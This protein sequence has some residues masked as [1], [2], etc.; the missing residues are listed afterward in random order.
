MINLDE[1]RVR[2]LSYGPKTD[3]RL[4]EKLLQVDPDILIALEGIGTVKGVTL[5]DRF[6]ELLLSGK[7]PR[8]F[9]LKLHEESTRRGHASLTTSLSIQLEINKCSRAASML[10]VAPPFGSYIQESQRRRIISRDDFV[11]PRRIASDQ[12]AKRI[13]EKAVKE[14]YEVYRFLTDSGVEIEDARYV[15]PLAS[16]TSLFASGSLD[17]FLGFII[18][19]KKLGRSS[20]IYPEELSLIGEGI[21]NAALQ[22]APILTKAKLLFKTNLP[23]YPYANPYKNEDPLVDKIIEEAGKP[24]EPKLLSFTCLINDK[25][26]IL[27]ALSDPAKASSLLPLLNAIFLEPLSLAAYHQSIR[28]RT[29]PTA[30][31]SIY[32]A[33]DRLA[34]Q[35][36]KSAIIPPRIGSS[37][38]LLRRFEDAIGLL[39]ESYELLRGLGAFRSD[40]IYLAPQA[41]RI[42]AIRLYNAFNLL[43]PQGY[44]A[45][46]TCSYS[47]WEERRVAYKIWN[48]IGEKA[49]EIA[50]IMGERCKLLGYCPEREWCEIILKY[51]EYDDD[52]HRKA[53]RRLKEELE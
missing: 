17:T 35:P 22:A 11:I 36:E 49:P 40:A 10:L 2:L 52:A 46:R 4:D 51:R 42:Y 14:S 48:S 25:G 16:A 39:I 30:V 6:R 28:H 27:E 33:F 19:S 21:L 3:L 31:E 44:I 45:M 26:L 43:W 50:S 29:V 53:L 24:E 7:D 23:T 13:F 20:D 47:Q 12:E 32:R 15:L 41:M 8:E 18:D 9:A 37:E 34:K 1:I 5:E 38:S